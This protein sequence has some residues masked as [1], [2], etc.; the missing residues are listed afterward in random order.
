MRWIFEGILKTL[1][2]RYGVGGI[3]GIKHQ[4]ILVVMYRRLDLKPSE[5]HLQAIYV[6]SYF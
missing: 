1:V 3:L 5:N 6:W 4:M 2:E